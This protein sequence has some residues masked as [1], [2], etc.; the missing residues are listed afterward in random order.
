VPPVLQD[1]IGGQIDL[2]FVP[3]SSVRDLGASGKVKVLGTTAA[4]TS[5]RMPEAKPISQMN[6]D[7]SSFVHGTWGAVF[8]ARTLPDAEVNRLHKALTAAHQDPVFQAQT[9]AT[10][11]DPAPV[12]SLVELERFYQTEARNYTSLAQQIGLKPE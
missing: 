1:L 2:T 4:Q 11:S 5:A 9:L 3:Q 6:P 12:M 7:L 10:G 8:V